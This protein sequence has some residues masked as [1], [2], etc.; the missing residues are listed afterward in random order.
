MLSYSSVALALLQSACTAVLALSGL[1]VLIGLTALAAA[2]GTY[3]PARGFHADVLRIPM[4]VLATL[5]AVVNLFV[6]ARVWRLRA[7]AG[8]WRKREVTP[9][10]KRNER[11]QVALAIVTLALVA[12]EVWTHPMVHKKPPAMQGIHSY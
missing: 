3:A 9:K 2:S 8:S 1:R 10:E 5:G 4:L 6:L 11:W 12:L 7:R